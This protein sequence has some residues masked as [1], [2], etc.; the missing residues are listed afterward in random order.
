[1]ISLSHLVWDGGTGLFQLR[2]LRRRANSV[3]KAITTSMPTGHTVPSGIN[4]KESNNRLW[5]NCHVIYVSKPF[6]DCLPKCL[7][8]W[9]H[10]DMCNQVAVA[11]LHWS[12]V[13]IGYILANFSV[14][15]WRWWT[16]LNCIRPSLAQREWTRPRIEV[17]WPSAND[18]LR[19]CSQS[20]LQLFRDCGLIA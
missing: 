7:K 20:V 2:R 13:Y 10:V 17:H 8:A 15:K 1:M 6:K 12:H 11:S 16:I 19:F 3:V 18:R 14:M 4:P 9:G 5:F